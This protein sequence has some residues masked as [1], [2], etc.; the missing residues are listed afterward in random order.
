MNWHSCSFCSL[1][2]LSHP[3]AGI[4]TAASCILLWLIYGRSLRTALHSVIV[5]F[6]CLLL[7]APWWAGVISLH[8]LAPFSL[9]V[10]HRFLRRFDLARLYAACS[11]AKQLSRS[12]LS[13]VSLEY[14]GVCGGEN[15]FWSHGPSFLSLSSR[16]ARQVS[17]S[18]HFVC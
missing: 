15:I 8:G 1:T 18:T 13:H 7:S 16:A 12:F 2:V 11:P 14:F 9:R 4:H 6:A 17:P 3:E 10:E 5:L